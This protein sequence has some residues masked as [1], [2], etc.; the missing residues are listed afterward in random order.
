M[1]GRTIRA[2]IPRISVKI[3]RG[4]RREKICEE[5]DRSHAGRRVES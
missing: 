1:D 4:G 5:A 3:P 2:K